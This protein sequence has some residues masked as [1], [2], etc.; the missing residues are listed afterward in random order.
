MIDLEWQKHLYPTGDSV[1]NKV[2]V[3]L[4][5]H[6]CPGLFCYSTL[7]S[8]TCNVLNKRADHESWTLKRVFMLCYIL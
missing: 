7:K 5:P 6:V 3:W 4:C 8:A 1:R 2:S